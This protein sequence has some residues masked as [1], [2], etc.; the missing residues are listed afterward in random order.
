MPG[1]LIRALRWGLATSMLLLP[2]TLPAAPNGE[3]LFNQHCASCHGYDGHGG[4]G[5]PLS[6]PSFLNS[7]P[8][9]YLEKTIRNGRQDSNY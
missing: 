9:D 6:L 7:V 5:V 8:D 1:L 4:V 3:A 2:F